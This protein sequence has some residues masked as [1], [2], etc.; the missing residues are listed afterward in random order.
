MNDNTRPG[1]KR[2]LSTKDEM[3]LTLMKLRLNLL[4]EDLAFR[5]KVSPSVVSQKI[6][7]WVPFWRELKHLIYWPT[8]EQLKKYYPACFKKY[9]VVR[10]I[11]DA[12]EV[13]LQK[14]SLAAANTV[15]FS[16]YKNHC[17]ST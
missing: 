1:R 3:F 10:V 13:V 8:K 12:T 11:I 5:F 2:T 6:S 7:T 15:I 17:T 14:S 4:E 16:Q 9:G